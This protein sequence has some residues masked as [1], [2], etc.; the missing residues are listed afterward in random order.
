[1]I[2]LALGILSILTITII[3][4]IVSTITIGLLKK[5]DIFNKNWFIYYILILIAVLTVITFTA[6]PSNYIIYKTVSVLLGLVG[7]LG[8][9]LG[10]TKKLDIKI[11]VVLISISLLGNFYIGFLM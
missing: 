10:K 11:N 7:V 6:L 1:M 3:I 5:N 2:S 4:L 8:V 9:Y